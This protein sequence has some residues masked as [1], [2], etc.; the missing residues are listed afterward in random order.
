MG[1]RVIASIT[2]I[3]LVSLIAGCATIKEKMHKAPSAPV[4]T[5]IA[6][7][8]TPSVPVTGEVESIVIEGPSSVAVG[9]TITLTAVGYDAQMSRIEAPGALNPVWTTDDP[10]VATLDGTEGASVALTGVSPGV[11]YIEV[12]QGEVKTMH[13]VE[14][15]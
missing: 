13:A 6:P 10:L 15:K 2:A 4:E 7:V 12:S 11:C 3:L 5:L 8:E 1:R 14:V 9:E